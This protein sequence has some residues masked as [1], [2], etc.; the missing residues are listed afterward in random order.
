MRYEV[1]VTH[2]YVT[3]VIL[4]A[5]DPTHAENLA[6]DPK[7]LPPFEEW[8][9]AGQDTQY[10]ACI[11]I[12]ADSLEALGLDATNLTGPQYLDALFGGEGHPIGV[13]GGPICTSCNTGREGHLLV[14]DDTD[15]WSAICKNTTE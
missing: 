4:E 14:R 15:H 7:R 13:N 1:R 11:P 5:D 2:R 8:A 9:F 12:E 6:E 3:R 10:I